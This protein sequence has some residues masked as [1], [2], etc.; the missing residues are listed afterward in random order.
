[1]DLELRPFKPQLAPT[2][3]S[4]VHSERDLLWLAPRTPPPLTAQKI[5]AWGSQRNTMFLL[6]LRDD[7]HPRAYGEINRMKR[8]PYQLWFGHLIVDPQMRRRG[9]GARFVAML[10]HEAFDSQNA[11]AVSLVVFPD[12][13]PAI[14]CY[15]SQGFTATREELLHL[16]QG[17][18]HRMLRM[19]ITKTRWITRRTPPLSNPAPRDRGI[20]PAS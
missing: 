9:I 1:M 10:L 16:P 2:V 14:R 5:L 13:Q 7:P 17:R 18:K 3:A 20:L 8:K 15:L 11:A 4:W 19:D 12:N 6:H